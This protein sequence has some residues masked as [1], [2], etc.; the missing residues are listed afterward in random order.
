MNDFTKEELEQILFDY[1]ALVFAYGKESID[2]FILNLRE[3]IYR[4]IDNYCDH[5]LINYCCGCDPE[6]IVCDKC[7]RDLWGKSVE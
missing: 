6:N 1:D 7:H 5:H 2:P 3:K 4:M